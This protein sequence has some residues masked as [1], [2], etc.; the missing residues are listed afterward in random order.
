MKFFS[1]AWHS[2]QMSED[3]ASRIPAEYETHISRLVPPLPA[4]AR[5]LVREVSLHDGL[6]RSLSHEQGKL[7]VSFRAGDQQ[8]G[9]FDAR[10][11]YT[12]VELTP[13][14]EQFLRAIIGNREVELLYDEFDSVGDGKHWFHRLLFWPYHEVSI[15][16]GAF[17][18]EITPAARRFD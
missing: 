2:G 12:G 16:F 4:S 14:S 3:E 1:P 5:R 18:L 10:L 17:E 9:Y 15:Q 8:V 6:M 7:D 13:G 11:R